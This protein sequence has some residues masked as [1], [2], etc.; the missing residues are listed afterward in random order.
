MR[1]GHAAALEAAQRGAAA[2]AQASR[3][4]V[5]AA[6]AAADGRV[7]GYRS[8]LETAVAAMQ[9]ELEGERKR[10]RLELEAEREACT[11]RVREMQALADKEASKWV[12]EMGETRK[13]DQALLQARARARAWG[14]RTDTATALPDTRREAPQKPST[15]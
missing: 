3:E 1:T 9:N 13:R 2:D 5:E 14:S 4:M 11:A 8:E 6:R 10:L 12:E 15:I 7:E